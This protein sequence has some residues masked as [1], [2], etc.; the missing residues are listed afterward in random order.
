MAIWVLTELIEYRRGQA[1]SLFSQRIGRG[2]PLKK[3]TRARGKREEERR[4]QCKKENV[5]HGGKP[6]SKLPLSIYMWNL[7]FILCQ[8]SLLRRCKC[9]AR[10]ET[11]R[12]TEAFRKYLSEV[13]AVA[14]GLQSR[15]HGLENLIS[16]SSKDETRE[17]DQLREK[18]A[19][20]AS[21]EARNQAVAAVQ[22][23]SAAHK[24]TIELDNL[25][26]H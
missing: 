19:L 3:R 5:P 16:F 7:G 26:V 2:P 23:V 22:S 24:A 6:D 18:L 17:L 9:S 21:K 25:D 11:E 10:L 1:K 8:M 4:R 15:V 20:E 12:Q 14:A 13:E